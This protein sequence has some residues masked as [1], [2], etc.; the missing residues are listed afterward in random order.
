MFVELDKSLYEPL[1]AE[2]KAYSSQKAK[3][4]RCQAALDEVAEQKK[5]VDE[6][7]EKDIRE[8]DREEEEEE[9]G[10]LSKSQRVF[11]RSVR[12]G[13]AD[14]LRRVTQRKS[15]AFDGVVASFLFC[16]R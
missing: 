12:Q 9:L 8:L 11:R 2:V 1:S 14:K 15:I 3:L 7:V 4:D 10:G 13:M 5:Q 6:D 16:F